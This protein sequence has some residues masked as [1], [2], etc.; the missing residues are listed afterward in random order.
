[1]LKDLIS[2]NSRT[3]IR[4]SFLQT[5]PKCT[6]PPEYQT[7]ESSKTRIAFFG[8]TLDLLGY[9]GDLSRERLAGRARHVKEEQISDRSMEGEWQS[10]EFF[11]P[12]S[13]LGGGI[14]REITRR[15]GQAI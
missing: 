4:A 9:D 15:V 2:N 6:I 12:R 5:C 13:M 14:G 10:T 3:A 1:M 11:V 8:Y 7:A